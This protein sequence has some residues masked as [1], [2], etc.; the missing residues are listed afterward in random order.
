[1]SENA[2]HYNQGT[3]YLPARA[4]CVSLTHTPLFQQKVTPD[5]FMLLQVVGRGNFGKVMQ[6][7]K[8][9]TGRIYAMKVLRKGSFLTC[10][11]LNGSCK[12]LS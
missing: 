1:M 2:I 12:F 8:K 7:R 10:Y 11:I 9:D 5:D 6:V 4:L 3:F